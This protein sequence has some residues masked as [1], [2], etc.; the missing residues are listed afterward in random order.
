M[1]AIT[2][3][4]IDKKI[5]T[6][7]TNRNTLRDL[8]HEIGMMILRHAAPKEVSADCS[9]SGD[10]TRALRLIE[11]MPKSWGE[12]MTA[13]FKA[14]SPIRVVVKNGKCEFAPEYKKLAPAQK[15]D[16]WNLEQAA[17]T[18]F[19]E[20]TE[21]PDAKPALDF[22]ALCKLVEGLGKR[23]ATK[24][25]KGEVKEE[26]RESALAIAKQ[27]QSLKL[28]RVKAPANTDTPEVPA[29]KQA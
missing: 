25:E 24:V 15:P 28:R 6:F 3:K 26:D 23:I 16:A 5:A 11:A 8:G 2:L 19:Y 18:P 29:K 13:W 21:E 22:A 1:T 7:T 9:G 14:F 10:C 12:Q 4:A 17:Q 27:V 20:A